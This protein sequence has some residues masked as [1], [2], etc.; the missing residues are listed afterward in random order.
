MLFPHQT[1]GGMD[2]NKAFKSDS[3]TEAH[4][5]FGDYFPPNTGDF[6]DSRALCRTNS[7]NLHRACHCCRFS[8]WGYLMRPQ[9]L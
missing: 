7:I 3:C 2:S 6:S 4:K 9:L 8:S 1:D 5:Y